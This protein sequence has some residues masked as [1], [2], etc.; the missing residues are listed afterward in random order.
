M[1]EYLWKFKSL[2]FLIGAKIRVRIFEYEYYNIY[3]VEKKY[4]NCT[5]SHIQKVTLKFLACISM[6]KQHVQTTHDVIISS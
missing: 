4:F 5:C 6:C 1:K 2:Q 3:L